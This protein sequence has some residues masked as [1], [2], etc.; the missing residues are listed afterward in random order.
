[1]VDCHPQAKI[2]VSSEPEEIK[3]PLLVLELAEVD[4]CTF[5]ESGLG[6]FSPDV[7]RSYAK[8]LINAVKY[9]D[10]KGVTHRDIKPENILLDHHFQLKLTDFGLARDSKGDQENFKLSSRVGSEGY[11]PP[12]M[13]SK[14]YVGLK[15]DLFAIGVII[16]IMYK[17]GPPFLGTWPGQKRFELYKLIK[18]GK[19]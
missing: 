9:L 11:Q 5:F 1:M 3:R 16:F 19:I 15:A 18:N 4:L 2:R 8:Q 17:G 6:A 13:E 7:C 10:S 12:E 14:N